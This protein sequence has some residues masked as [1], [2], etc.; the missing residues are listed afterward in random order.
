M[1]GD[2][3]IANKRIRFKNYTPVDAKLLS[4]DG[5]NNSSNSTVI[6]TNNANVIKNELSKLDSSSSDDK[7]INIVPKKVNS[8]LKSQIDDKMAKLNRRTQL[9]IVEILREKLSKEED[10]DNDADDDLD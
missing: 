8:D 3:M 4:S 9:A 5:S 6:N 10:N 2:T 1:I 7:E